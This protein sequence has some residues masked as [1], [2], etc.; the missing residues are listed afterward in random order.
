MKLIA[1]TVSKPCRHL[2]LSTVIR[3]NQTRPHGVQGNK[4]HHS[5]LSLVAYASHFPLGGY[6]MITVLAP[7]T[8]PNIASGTQMFPGYRPKNV[9]YA[10]QLRS[11]AMGKEGQ[12]TARDNQSVW[13]IQT[14]NLQMKYECQSTRY[15]GCSPEGSSHR[16]RLIQHLKQPRTIGRP[17]CVVAQVQCESK[18]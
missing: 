4:M 1:K 5:T 13:G 2:P 18:I 3:C 7:F 16:P 6:P 11:F 17:L 14:D 10:T 8:L 9:P 15:Q 12:P